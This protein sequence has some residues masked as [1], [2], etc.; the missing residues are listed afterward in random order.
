MDEESIAVTAIPTVVLDW[1]PALS[2]GATL[3]TLH[4][5]RLGCWSESV[6]CAADQISEIARALRMTDVTV[7]KLIH[8]LHERGALRLRR[9]NGIRE[10]TLN[11]D[12]RP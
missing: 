10:V 3:L 8:D 9:E 4:L 6:W 12:W 5:A 2:K 7:R 1:L 11:L